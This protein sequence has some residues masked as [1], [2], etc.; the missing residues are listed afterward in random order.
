MHYSLSPKYTFANYCTICA[1]YGTILP[2]LIFHTEILSYLKTTQVRKWV[3]KQLV[4]KGP[5]WEAKSLQPSQEVPFTQIVWY[6]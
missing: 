5:P 3:T 4:E 2:G 1:R 6:V